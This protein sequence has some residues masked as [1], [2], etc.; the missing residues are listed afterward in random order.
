MMRECLRSAPRLH[1]SQ[2]S[3]QHEVYEAWMSRELARHGYRTNSGPLNP[4][5]YRIE[6]QGLLGGQRQ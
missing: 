1:V 6:A 3:A 4:T 5:L 2:H